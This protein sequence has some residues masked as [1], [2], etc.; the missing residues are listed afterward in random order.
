MNIDNIFARS[1]QNLLTKANTDSNMNEMNGVSESF[2][3]VEDDIGGI[4]IYYNEHDTTNRRSSFSLFDVN[5]DVNDDDNDDHENS[6]DSF[7]ESLLFSCVGCEPCVN[8]FVP[9][10]HVKS[11]LKNSSMIDTQR[12]YQELRTV[13]SAH[14]MSTR[15]VSFNS[16]NVKEFNMTLGDHPSASSGPPMRLDWNSQPVSRVVSLDE[17]EEMRNPIRRSRKQLRLSY[18]DRK[19]ILFNDQGLSKEEVND[20]WREALKIRQQR[21]ET[22]K[23]GVSPY[24]ISV[25]SMVESMHRKYKRFSDS[26]SDAVISPSLTFS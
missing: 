18:S 10:T 3:V 19:E 16:I 22:L 5:D 26:I 23:H 7:M 1:Q 8:G 9:R 20:A 13:G 12:S 17:Y 2:E 6:S 11:I 15:T 14:S 4:Q 21:A 25:D 24:Q